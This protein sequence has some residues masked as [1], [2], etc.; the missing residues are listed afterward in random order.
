[1]MILQLML[2]VGLSAL[3]FASSSFA[4]LLSPKHVCVAMTSTPTSEDCDVSSKKRRS[5]VASS[6]IILLPWQFKGDVYAK[7]VVES[8]TDTKRIAAYISKEVDQQFLSSVIKSNYNFLYRGLSS[9]QSKAT[10]VDRRFAAAIILKDEPFDLLDA[11]TYESNEAAAYF[12]SL[13]EELTTLKPSNSHI[14]TTCPKEAAKWGH[15]ASI[16]PLGEKGVEFAWLADG[17]TFWPISDGTSKT[18]KR[19][20][21]TSSSAKQNHIKGKELSDALLQ[22]DAWDIMFRAD[23]GFLAVPIELDEELRAYLM[24][25]Q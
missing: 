19:T 2:V 9:E 12:Q 24:K 18:K 5:Y 14:G 8:I 4:V 22:D 25:M 7:E 20:I 16:W 10:K 23:N 1:M 6:I 17:G 3:P 13:E 15:A 21:I 11:S